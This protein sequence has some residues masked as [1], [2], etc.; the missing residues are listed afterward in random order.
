[1]FGIAQA[2]NSQGGQYEHLLRCLVQVLSVL[3]YIKIM[4]FF[5]AEG[6]LP[7]APDAPVEMHV[8][9]VISAIGLQTHL[10]SEA[11]SSGSTAAANQPLNSNAE[12]PEYRRGVQLV[13]STVQ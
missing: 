10:L 2:A 11:D 7:K 13:C 6:D 12:T 3:K 9:M 8:L 5:Q 4:A 1:M